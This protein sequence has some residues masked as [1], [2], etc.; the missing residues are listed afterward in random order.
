MSA[1]L[2]KHF[3]APLEY[4]LAATGQTLDTFFAQTIPPFTRLQTSPAQFEHM[5]EGTLRI[6]HGS[7]GRMYLAPA[8]ALA[9]YFGVTPFILFPITCAQGYIATLTSQMVT[10]DMLAADAAL[11]ARYWSF[12]SQKY[13]PDMGLGARQPL[14]K[15]DQ[16]R[17]TRLAESLHFYRNCPS[18]ALLHDMAGYKDMRAFLTDVL[19]HPAF[20]E[21]AAQHSD[22]KLVKG[23]MKEPY[24]RRLLDALLKGEVGALKT[25]SATACLVRV[26]ALRNG[27]PEGSFLNPLALLH[28]LVSLD[29][30]TPQRP[31]YPALVI[32]VPPDGF[33]ACPN[34]LEDFL[35]FH[36]GNVS[37]L[38][39]QLPHQYHYKQV[40]PRTLADFMQA[41]PLPLRGR[42]GQPTP[43]AL[44]AHFLM[45]RWRHLNGR[46][47][48]TF[49]KSF[50]EKAD[51]DAPQPARLP[52]PVTDPISTKHLP[53]FV[54]ALLQK[55][56]FDFEKMSKRLVA[57]LKMSAKD[58]RDWVETNPLAVVDENGK[59][60]RGAL[61]FYF[62]VG[63]MAQ[64]DKS[65][66][67]RVPPIHA[68]YG[69]PERNLFTPR[70]AD[71]KRA[72]R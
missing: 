8:E 38:F 62:L 24:A 66:N 28:P 1:V 47:L 48:M 18:M 72:E 25:G 15:D 49:S 16:L 56:H 67:T 21:F 17:L 33:P 12:I 2:F 70:A 35:A 6:M 32:P 7:S 10:N 68:V 29:E 23:A 20:A 69:V 41:D 61:A 57:S 37:V 26:L 4:A 42:D 14:P 58:M 50:G 11:Y 55:H 27:V 60:T 30:G 22:S 54:T 53:T 52:A 40:T 46:P 39:G 45:N 44:C 31:T 9:Q 13:W 59:Y 19:R 34:D 3:A 71:A 51:A 43:V 65:A 36:G 63:E 64:K 5:R